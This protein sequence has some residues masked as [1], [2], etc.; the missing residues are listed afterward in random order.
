MFFFCD[1]PTSLPDFIAKVAP[2]LYNWKLP[3][4]DVEALC[5]SDKV[6][7]LL[8][9]IAKLKTLGIKG[10]TISMSFIIRKIQPLKR[11]DKAG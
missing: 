8:D 3:K 11:Q 4:K 2:V 1:N 6:K 5:Q 10:E 7:Y 9:C